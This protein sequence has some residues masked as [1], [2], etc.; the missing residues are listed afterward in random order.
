M[1]LSEGKP[2]SLDEVVSWLQKHGERGQRVAAVIDGLR[3][4]VTEWRTA[5][6][7]Q[8]V[9]NARLR[10]LLQEANA[11]WGDLDVSL[12]KRIRDALEGRAS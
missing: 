1:T 10:D 9:T 4:Q 8:A 2:D 3:E 11:K 6:A 7:N 12:S 5:S